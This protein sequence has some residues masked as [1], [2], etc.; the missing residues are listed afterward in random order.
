MLDS[1]RPTDGENGD[2]IASLRPHYAAFKEQALG[3][4]ALCCCNPSD[5]DYESLEEL[6][7][8]MHMLAGTATLFGEPAVGDLASELDEALT[9]RR[10]PVRASLERARSSFA[11]LRR[12]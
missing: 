5:G 4:L 3:Q 11:D 12:S 2:A 6:R 7:T 1:D 9:R 10:E 8:L